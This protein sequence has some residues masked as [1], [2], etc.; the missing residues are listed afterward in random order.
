MLRSRM[1]LETPAEESRPEEVPAA[2]VQVQVQVP[3]VTLGMLAVLVAGFVGELVFGV[4]PISGPLGPDIMTLV[5][6][7]GLSRTLVQ[8]GE[9]WRFFTAAFLHGDLVHLIMNGV[10]LLLAG[11]TLE[12]LI[13][14]AWLLALFVL[15]A[16]GG[17]A[18][19]FAWN[20]PNVVSVGA[21]GAIMGLL[22]AP[23]ASP[24]SSRASSC[25]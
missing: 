22:A 5:A 17:S 13:G 8:S 25:R 7:G 24:R 1:S 21:S 16:L 12:P 2:P 4:A 9:W 23:S 11:W 19:S 18:M 10:A 14:R 6:T 15:G 3:W 20:D